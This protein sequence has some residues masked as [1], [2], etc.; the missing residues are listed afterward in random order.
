MN[1]QIIRLTAEQSIDAHL[2]E[3]WTTIKGPATIVILKEEAA[4]GTTAPELLEAIKR[5]Q[6]VVVR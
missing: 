6:R 2:P 4:A 1:D 3:G 5:E